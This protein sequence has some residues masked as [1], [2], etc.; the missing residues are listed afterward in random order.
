M[1]AVV[2]IFIA[3]VVVAMVAA[4]SASEE[5]ADHMGEFRSPRL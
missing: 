2:L 3:I 5:I 4:G 1:I